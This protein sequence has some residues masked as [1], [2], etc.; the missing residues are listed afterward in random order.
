MK[1]TVSGPLGAGTT[2]LCRGLKRVTG[3]PYIYAGQIFRDMAEEKAMSLEAFSRL[4]EGD[5]K[6][7][8]EIDRRM[9]DFAYGNKDVIV[10]GR[11]AGW[12]A[13]REKKAKFFKIWLDAPLDFRMERVAH[14][15]NESLVKTEGKILVREES[16]AKRYK[17]IYGI[18]ISDL[19]IYD[20]VVNNKDMGSKKTLNVIIKALGREG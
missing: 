15:E 3:Y 13:Y 7:D 8:L 5:D 2:T 4:A 6:Y 17:K 19:S 20:L 9:M 11:L 14:R 16:E 1:I 10:E 18:D 12:F